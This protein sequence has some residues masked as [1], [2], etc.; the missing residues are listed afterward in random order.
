MFL[1]LSPIIFHGEAG[2]VQIWSWAEYKKEWLRVNATNFT[3][4]SC[5]VLIQCSSQSG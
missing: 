3:I 4:F 1:D 2:P 5:I